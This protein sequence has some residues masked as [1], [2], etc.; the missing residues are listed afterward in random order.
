MLKQN[1]SRQTYTTC[2][3]IDVKSLLKTFRAIATQ[4]RAPGDKTTRKTAAVHPGLRKYANEKRSQ[5]S[6]LLGSAV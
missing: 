4:Q 3:E 6:C 2:Q 5:P 1:L